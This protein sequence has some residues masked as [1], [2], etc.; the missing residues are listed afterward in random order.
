MSDGVR[1]R[2]LLAQNARGLECR[3]GRNPRVAFALVSLDQTRLMQPDPPS[4]E[5]KSIVI[6][7][8]VAGN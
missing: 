1:K 2:A 3:G 7:P 8:A 5:A 6:E 4:P